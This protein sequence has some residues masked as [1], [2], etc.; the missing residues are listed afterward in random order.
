MAVRVIRTIPSRGFRIT[1][2]LTRSTSTLFFPCQQSA[3]T[4]PPKLF[5]RQFFLVAGQA[6]FR[7]KFNRWP[8]VIK[9]S[10]GGA[11]DAARSNGLPF[12]GG[13]FTSF[14]ELLDLAKAFAY[15]LFGMQS[16]QGRQRM[17]NRTSRGFVFQRD[18]DLGAAI[19]GRW[20][21]AHHAS[22]LDYLAFRGPGNEFSRLII[23]ELDMR[24]EFRSIFISKAQG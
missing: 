4:L 11:A 19:S 3:F 7:L 23:R 9:D 20:F 10:F 22:V 15:Q 1:G 21:E 5:S 8:F 17:R 16:C 6:L 2:S 24:G 14:H 13:N 18:A 12:G